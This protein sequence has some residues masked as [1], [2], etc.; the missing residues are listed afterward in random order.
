MPL[1]ATCALALPT[2]RHH[3]HLDAAGEGGLLEAHR[4]P[5]LLDAVDA[6]DYDGSIAR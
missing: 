5:D 4:V 6:V 2:P 1:A 3:D